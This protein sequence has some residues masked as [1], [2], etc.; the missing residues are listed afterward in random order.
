MNNIDN[1]LIESDKNTL[2]TRSQFIEN[3]QNWVLID[4]QLKIINEKTT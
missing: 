3:L 4:S 1:Q 2:T